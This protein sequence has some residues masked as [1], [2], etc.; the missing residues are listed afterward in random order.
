[1]DIVS[2]DGLS[3]WYKE[4]LTGNYEITYRVQVVVENGSYDRLSDLNCFWGA[5]DP[6]HPD[7]FFARSAWRNGE[8]KNYNT[9]DLYYVATAVMIMELRVSVNTMESIMEWT[10]AKIKPILREYTDAAHL[11]KPNHWYEVKIRVENGA[12]T[13]AMDGEELFSFT[14]CR[15]Q[16]RRLFRLTVVAEPRTF[17]RFPSSKYR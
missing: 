2:P 11:L 7:D 16:R 4:R 10:S 3:L 1:M 17:C 12:T 8:F 6:R 14:G 9:L 15:W 5:D 13:Y